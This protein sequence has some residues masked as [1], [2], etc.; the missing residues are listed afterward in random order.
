MK[1]SFVW[2]K[3]HEYTDAHLL[4]TY[5]LQSTMRLNPITYRNY[6]ALAATRTIHCWTRPDFAGALSCPLHLRLRPVPR[7]L[8]HPRHRKRLF[9][10]PRRAGPTPADPYFPLLQLSGG[11]TGHVTSA[12]FRK[13]RVGVILRILI[14][15][16]KALSR[17][18][19]QLCEGVHKV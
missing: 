6:P 19:Q 16:P 5:R 9:L 3:S 18:H 4:A 13:A 7:P 14:E 10:L 17:D 8:S 15:I 2:S 1:R 12:T 11:N